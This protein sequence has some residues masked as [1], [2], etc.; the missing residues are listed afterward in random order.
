MEKGSD[1][2]K[3]K[4][5]M[6]I[7]LDKCTGCGTCVDACPMECIEVNAEEKAIVDAEECGDCGA[8]I[9]ECPVEAIYTEEDL[10][11]G[12]EKWTAINAEK[13][14]NLPVVAEREDPLPGA[15][16]RKKDLGL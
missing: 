3:Y 11:S 8:C 4:Y 12:E 7:D 6:V 14:P 16:A 10:P 2:G 13:S 9:D 1:H 15:E 5:G